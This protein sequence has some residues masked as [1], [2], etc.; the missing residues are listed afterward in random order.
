MGRQLALRHRTLM[1]LGTQRLPIETVMATPS[2]RLRP[3]LTLSETRQPLIV[4]VMVTRR[5]RQEAIR[6]V[7]AIP[8]HHI[9]TYTEGAGGHRTAIP[10]VS[11]IPPRTIRTVMVSPLAPRQVI[12]MPLGIQQPISAATTQARVSGVG[13]NLIGGCSGISEQPLIRADKVQLISIS[14]KFPKA[15]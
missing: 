3:I 11:A 8:R 14:Y 6:I 7:L 13:S 2:E 10:T 9:P 1:L 12:L 4:T 15:F 5:E